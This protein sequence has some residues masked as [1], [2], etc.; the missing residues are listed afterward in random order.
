MQTKAVRRAR[1]SKHSETCL[2]FQWGTNYEAI[3]NLN[4]Y[5]APRVLSESRAGANR[6]VPGPL[7]YKRPALCPAGH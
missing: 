7:R 5:V 6:P 4:E 1:Q 2:I 3:V